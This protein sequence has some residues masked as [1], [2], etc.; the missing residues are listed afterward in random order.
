MLDQ[1]TEIQKLRLH[2]NEVLIVKY[3][4]GNLPHGAWKRNADSLKDVLQTYLLSRNV[5][6]IGDD[7]HFTVIEKEN[8]ERDYTEHF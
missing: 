5:L 6:V 8:T 7:I 2:E 1:I 4:V 3:P